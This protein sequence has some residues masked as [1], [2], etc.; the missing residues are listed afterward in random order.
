MFKT[1]S[2]NIIRNEYDAVVVGAGIGGLVSACYLAKVGMSVLLIEKNKQPGGYCTSFNRCGYRFDSCV[3]ALSSYRVGGRLHRVIKDL[4]LLDRFQVNRHDPA[5]IMYAPQGRINYSNDL[6]GAV[7]ELAQYFP[8][9]RTNIEKFLRFVVFSSLDEHIK[10]RSFTFAQLLDLYFSNENL[11]TVLAV[12]IFGLVGSHPKRLSALVASLIYRE[13][14]F[15]GGYYPADGVQGFA[16]IL[17]TRFIEY[18]GEYLNLK[19]VE[20]VIVE[21]KIAK[22]VVLDGRE[23]IFARNVILNG[24][25]KYTCPEL[26]G[27]RERIKFSRGGH[28]EFTRSLSAFAVYLGMRAGFQ[29]KEEFKSN[30]WVLTEYDMDRIV[31]NDHEAGTLFVIT[32]PS[33][34]SSLD[35]DKT[36]RTVCI[37]ALAQYHEKEFWNKR[38]RD[39][40][41]NQLIEMAEKVIPNLSKHIAY[42]CDASPCSMYRWTLN[43]CGAAYGWESTPE[44]FGAPEWSQKT[45]I[46]N[47]YLASHWS[48]QSSGVTSVVNS[49]LDV[50]HAILRKEQK[51]YMLIAGVS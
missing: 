45:K 46:R 42:R 50:A 16:D 34:K 27:R 28:H 39:R 37:T 9:E 21:N 33:S 13:F 26:Y 48:N 19:T 44:Q 30:I 41:S 18:G 10:L 29:E 6:N 7:D 38:V 24:D 40:I 35:M 15:D 49:G 2:V 14:I 23:Q 1:R 31:C 5:N 32:S 20:S 11:K 25:P 4:N 43:T 22:G 12:V 47:L 51:S 3:H 17:L 8:E 36:M